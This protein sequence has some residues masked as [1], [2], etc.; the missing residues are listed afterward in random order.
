MG[1]L[2]ETILRSQAVCLERV[3]RSLIRPSPALGEIQYEPGASVLFPLH[4][5]FEYAIGID[6]TKR[7]NPGRLLLEHK[8]LV[9]P[10]M[11]QCLA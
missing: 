5:T 10:E 6:L 8:A 1:D 11:G 2:G 4:A 3:A 9:L 7:V